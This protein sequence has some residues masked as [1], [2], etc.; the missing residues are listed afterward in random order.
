M[1]ARD[2]VSE[3]GVPA[4]ARVFPSAEEMRMV[5]AIALLALLQALRHGE[6]RATFHGFRVEAHRR[7][8]HGSRPSTVE[9]SLSVRL[10]GHVVE[11]SEL[12]IDTMPA[13]FCDGESCRTTVVRSATFVQS[14]G[15]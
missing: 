1:I 15:H 2:A 11:R 8:G 6:Y 4:K 9:V 14:D 13:S 10:A 3:L 7:P 12:A 5:R